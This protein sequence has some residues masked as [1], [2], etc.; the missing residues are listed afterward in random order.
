M[1]HG[2]NPC[3]VVTSLDLPNPE[4]LYRALYCARGQDESWINMIKKDLAGDRRSDHCFLA[5]PLRLFLSCAANLL[6]HA[7]RTEVLVHT[8]TSPG[9]AR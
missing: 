8:G 5:K 2:D 6:Y 7:P 3:F 1:G 9:A 4:S